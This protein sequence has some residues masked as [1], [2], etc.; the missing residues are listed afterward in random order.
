VVSVQPSIQDNDYPAQSYNSSWC[1]YF[2][3]EYNPTTTAEIITPAG[4]IIDASSIGGNF[5]VYLIRSDNYP[6]KTKTVMFVSDGS[7]WTA[8]KLSN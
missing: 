2:C 7:N 6:S 5:N 3:A 8:F 4:Q 1:H